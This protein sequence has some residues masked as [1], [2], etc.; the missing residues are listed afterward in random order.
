MS[1]VF[2][3]LTSH[4]IR[5]FAHDKE[6]GIKHVDILADK[7]RVND[8]PLHLRGRLAFVKVDIE[9]VGAVVRLYQQVHKAISV[10][11]REDEVVGNDDPFEAKRFPIPHQAW[12]EV[13]NDEVVGE[14]NG[15]GDLKSAHHWVVCCFGV[16]MFGPEISQV[17]VQVAQLQR[18]GRRR[19]DRGRSGHVATC[20][21]KKMKGKNANKF[22]NSVH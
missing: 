19:D 21:L 16:T 2:F 22:E 13:E 9:Q 4:L 20:K 14:M 5:L 11:E 15:Q 17:V 12:A 7:V 10:E 3:L 8:V 18:G 6:D 1:S